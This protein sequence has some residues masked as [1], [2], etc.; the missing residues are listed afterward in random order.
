MIASTGATALIYRLVLARAFAMTRRLQAGG[1]Q[2]VLYLD[3]DCEV[4]D[5]P[6][7]RTALRAHAAALVLA[8]S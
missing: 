6:E 3:A 2:P 4:M 1:I 8:N 5:P 7:L